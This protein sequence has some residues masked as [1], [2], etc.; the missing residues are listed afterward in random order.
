MSRHYRLIGL[1]KLTK[2]RKNLKERIRL[3]KEIY[4]SENTEIVSIRKEFEECEILDLTFKWHRNYEGFGNFVEF[5]KPI[6]RGDERLY[7][8]TLLEGK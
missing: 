8:T 2:H 4:L 1:T 6:Y 5:S 3:S 7:E